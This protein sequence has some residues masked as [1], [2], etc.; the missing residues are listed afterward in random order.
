M[1]APPTVPQTV[2]MFATMTAL[3]AFILVV[4]Y[5]W[6]THTL[7]SSG[8]VLMFALG[9]MIVI[10]GCVG[11]LIS[12]LANIILRAGPRKLRLP[13]TCASWIGFC[14]ISY[15]LLIDMGADPERSLEL[16]TIS[17]VFGLLIGPYHAE[18]FVGLWF[19][20]RSLKVIEGDGA[21]KLAEI[22]R[23]T[24]RKQEEYKRQFQ[25][26]RDAFRNDEE[27]QRAIRNY[28]RS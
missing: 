21:R 11:F 20:K 3:C 6:G 26:S 25:A 9:G 18:L 28:F 22:R 4:A 24:A 12:A 15:A 10:G 17:G 23:E 27:R 13:L 5:G 2:G 1:T 19:Y 8:N 7:P 14:V 16:S